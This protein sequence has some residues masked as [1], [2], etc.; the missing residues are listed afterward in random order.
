M[1]P[2]EEKQRITALDTLRGIAILGIIPANMPSFAMPTA[3]N[4]APLYMSSASSESLSYFV[5]QAFVDL[6]FL[7]IF[8]MLFGAGMA[9]QFKKSEQGLE[10]AGQY[11]WRMVLLMLIATGHVLL[12]WFGDILFWYALIGMVAMI[13]LIA[14]PPGQFT[15]GVVFVFVGAL[16]WWALSQM[17]TSQVR[18]QQQWT[19]ARAM[20]ELAASSIESLDNDIMNIHPGVETVRTRDGDFGDIFRLRM[21]HWLSLALAFM[22]IYGWRVLGLFL[23][24]MALMNTDYFHPEGRNRWRD[25]LFL[26]IGLTLGLGL[27]VFWG[28]S[29]TYGQVSAGQW[30]RLEAMHQISALFLSL[31]YMTLVLNMPSQWCETGILSPFT[32]V[33]RMALS[34]YLG[35]SLICALIFYGWGFGQFGSWTRLQIWGG[36]AAIGVG[37]MV[38]S[39][40]WMRFFKFGPVEWLWRSAVHF[41]RQPLWRHS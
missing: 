34:N 39:A 11:L 10:F 36:S 33:G 21:R 2:V 8:A 27:E 15:L 16:S 29:N 31:A 1:K 25:G 38:F 35:T 9:L 13:F 20:K 3:A 28:Q 17:D 32:K 18:D 41:E 12:L 23:I 4:R 14:P 26:L 5:W 24:G 37:L 6:K 30:M 40:L 7:T 22:L 19:H